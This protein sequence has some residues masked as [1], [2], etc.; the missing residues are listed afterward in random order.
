MNTN[1]NSVSNG[2]GQCVLG[3]LLPWDDGVA[4]PLT[5]ERLVIGSHRLCNIVI[6][7]AKVAP[8]SCQLYLHDGWW[9]VRN[10][11]SETEV[12]LNGLAFLEERLRPGDV[13]W[14]GG[15]HKFR[16][17]YEPDSK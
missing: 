16:V 12:K 14:I 8:V 15:R 7:S 4:I 10:L 11:S 5:K 1:S 13:L 3:E 9:Y 2:Q 6:R 17:H